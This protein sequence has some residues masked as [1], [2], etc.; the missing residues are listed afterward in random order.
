MLDEVNFCSEYT[1]TNQVLG[2]GSNGKVL[3]AFKTQTGRQAACKIVGINRELGHRGAGEREYVM[4]EIKI[5][6]GLERHPNI[7]NVWDFYQNADRVYIF[8]ELV[9]GGDLFSFVASKGGSLEEIYCL[10]IVYQICK[11]LS[12]LHSQGIIH[13]DLKVYSYSAHP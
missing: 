8:Q 3:L 4:R 11:A 6:N 2:I 7:I 9:T 1:L 13:R 5:L 12:F 10:P